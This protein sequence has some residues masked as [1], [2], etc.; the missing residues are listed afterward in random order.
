[1]EP[2]KLSSPATAEISELDP[3]RLKEAVK[4]AFP[5][6]GMTVSGLRREIKRGRLECEVIAGKQFVT[7]RDINLMRQRC[8]DELRAPVSI[9]ASAGDAKMCGSS[10]TDKTKSALASALAVTEKLKKSSTIISSGSTDQTGK[11]VTLQR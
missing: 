1:M 6:G 2:F 10:S 3:L 8:R 4:I 7:R 9:S 11:K 5:R